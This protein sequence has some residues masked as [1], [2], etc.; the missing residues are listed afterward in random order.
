MKTIMFAKGP[1]KNTI[2]VKK[3]LHKYNTLLTI[4]LYLY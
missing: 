4:T 2:Q 3:I 1:D